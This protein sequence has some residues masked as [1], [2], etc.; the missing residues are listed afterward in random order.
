M[1]GTDDLQ[2]GLGPTTIIFVVTAYL[3]E[4]FDTVYKNITYPFILVS[5]HT[6]WV[7]DSSCASSEAESFTAA[8]CDTPSWQVLRRVAKFL[9]PCAAHYASSLDVDCLQYTLEPP[10]PP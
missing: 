9:N 7:T 4:F 10:S 8:A 1:P 5:G 6:V 2:V 3:K